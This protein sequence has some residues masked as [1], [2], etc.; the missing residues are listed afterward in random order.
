MKA[1][2]QRVTRASVKIEGK[3]T[4]QI[5]YGYLALIGMGAGDNEETCISMLE[6][7][8]KLRLFP[9]QDGKTNLDITNVNGEILIVSQ[10]TL[11]ADCRK[12]TRPGFTDAAPP[13]TA[14]HLYNYFLEKAKTY[15]PMVQS[16]VFGAKMEVELVNDGPFTIIL[17]I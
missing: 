13:Q 8:K 11:Y 7:I 17:E 9:D 6:K 3:I 1:V 10:F 2:L 15:F 5:N 14:E 12:G 16:G 4:G